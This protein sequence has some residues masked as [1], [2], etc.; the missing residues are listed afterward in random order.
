MWSALSIE[1]VAMSQPMHLARKEHNDELYK[2]FSSI[3]YREVCQMP[4]VD[5]YFNNLGTGH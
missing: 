4:S 2:G 5:K 1:G 3:T